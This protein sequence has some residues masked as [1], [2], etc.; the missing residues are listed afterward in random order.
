MNIQKTLFE[1]KDLKYKEFHAKLI[2]D[3]EK[4]RIIGV[5][6]PEL[7]KLA[8]EYSKDNESGIF[9]KS[10]PHG[11]Y[12][13][14]NL[15]AFLIENIKDFDKA[16]CETKKFLPYIDNWATCDSFL[17]PVFKKN[18]DKL[19]P[20]IL[21][22]IKSDKTYTVR[23]AI[24][25]LMKLYSEENFKED[26]LKEV[27]SIKSN[28]YYIKMAIAW[29]FA[30]LLARQYEKTIPYIENHVLDHWTHNKAIQKAS[31]S[32]RISKETKEYLKALKAK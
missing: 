27:S 10:L 23:Y 19:L 24:V 8:K 26:F 14:N 3:I 4:E 9:L 18:T 2:P 17:P 11:Y 20:E 12:E 5:R 22:W 21:K 30:E 1:L 28:E 31:E 15:H 25:L 7:R 16:L 29:Y 13:E 6:I 32:Y